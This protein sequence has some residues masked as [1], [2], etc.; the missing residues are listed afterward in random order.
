MATTPEID[1]AEFVELYL[2]ATRR[3]RA[4]RTIGTLRQRLGYATRVYGDVPLRE[5]ERM[6]DELAGWAARLP[7]RSRYGIVSALRQT[8]GAAVRWG[9]MSRTRPS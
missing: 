5:L 8:L 3:E 7:D 2:D 9:Y 6:V 4:P 1:L